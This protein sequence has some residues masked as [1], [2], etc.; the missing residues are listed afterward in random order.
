MSGTVCLVIS[1]TMS[2]VS[3]SLNIFLAWNWEIGNELPT[4]SRAYLLYILLVPPP[5]KSGSS[6]GIADHRISDRGIVESLNAPGY[7]H[8]TWTEVSSVEHPGAVGQEYSP[9]W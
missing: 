1:Y 7:C 9:Y 6:V 2:M 3:P 4:A 8:V 5:C